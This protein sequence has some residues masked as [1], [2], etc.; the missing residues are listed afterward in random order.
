MRD[1]RIDEYARLLVERSVGVQPGWEV[2]ILE[3]GE[4]F[5]D[6]VLESDAGDHGTGGKAK[7]EK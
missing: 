1:A 2:Q 5:A 3:C 4:L 7:G 6:Q